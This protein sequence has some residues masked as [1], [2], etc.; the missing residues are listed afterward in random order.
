LQNT[1]YAW[2][3]DCFELCIVLLFVGPTVAIADEGFVYLIGVYLFFAK[4]SGEI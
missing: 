1:K 3:V 2:Y 4:K